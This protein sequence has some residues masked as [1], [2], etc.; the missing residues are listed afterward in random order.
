MHLVVNFVTC[1]A[2]H[3][4]KYS[5]GTDIFKIP[6]LRYKSIWHFLLNCRLINIEYKGVR[7]VK[8]LYLKALSMLE[9]NIFDCHVFK[10]SG[11]FPRRSFS[12]PG[13]QFL[14]CSAVMRNYAV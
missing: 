6:R 4:I 10:V 14:S 13:S 9:I 11:G 12:I 1:T 7:K 8:Y 3:S 5:N 2:L